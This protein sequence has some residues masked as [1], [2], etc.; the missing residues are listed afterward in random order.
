[1][2]G[3]DGGDP[4]SWK[5]TWRHIFAEGGLIWIKF[6][7]LVQNDMSTAVMWS[8][9]KSDVEFQYGRCLGKFM[10]CHPRATCHIAGC[11]HPSNS[12]SWS[13][14]YV[15][16]CRVLPS[17]EFNGVSSQSHVL[18]CRVLPLG[19]FTVTIPE[20]HATL[21]G[22]IIQSAILKIIFRHI[23]FFYFL[24]QF[25]L[26]RAAQLS[27]RLRYTCVICCAAVVCLLS[28]CRCFSMTWTNTAC[29][30]N[31]SNR[32]RC[33]ILSLYCISSQGFFSVQ[34]YTK[35]TVLN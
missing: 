27:Y 23:L 34:L 17:S 11:C 35:S 18:H 5:S 26:W 10:A 19:E 20:L 14:S 3:K 1:M 9:T 33:V 29:S 24:M 28:Y 12:M 8:K 30:W 15:S 7:R 21:Q 13:Q 25:R 32:S 22:V 16:H 31:K 4:P 6:C 2:A